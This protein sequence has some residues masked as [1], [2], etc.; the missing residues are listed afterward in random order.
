[1]SGIGLRADQRTAA[2]GVLAGVQG[3]LETWL[4]RTCE[5]V[6]YTERV[7]AGYDG[8]I[9]PR[10]TPIQSVTSLSPVYSDG[11]L[12]S[13]VAISYYQV[14]RNYIEYDVLNGEEFQLI[15]S[16]GLDVRNIPTLKHA[17]L[18]VAARIMTNRHDD[19]MSARGTEGQPLESPLLEGWQEDELKKLDRWRHK[20]AR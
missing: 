1:M 6:D 2:E 18:K 19:S 17:I 16:A 3:E 10:W 8:M 15:Y 4:N 12:G 14:K 13:V 5:I 7:F 20:I 9:A 11:T